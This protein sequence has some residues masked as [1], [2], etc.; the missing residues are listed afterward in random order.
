MKIYRMI[1]YDMR[2]GFWQNRW[3]LLIMAALALFFCADFY[4]YRSN[5]YRG[6]DVPKAT[7]MDYLF[8]FMSGAKEYHVGVDET[9]PFP[10]KWFLLNAYFLYSTLYYSNRDLLG[11]GKVILPRAKS[12]WSWWLS[13]CVWN[14]LYTLCGYG[15]LYA[16]VLLWCVVMGERVSFAITAP[17][18]DKLLGM[19]GM[20]TEYAMM[21]SFYILL[22]PMMTVIS[23]SI[24]QTMFSLITRPVFSFGIM[25][26]IFVLS[27]YFQSSI[28]IGN[29]AMPIRSAY[30]IEGGFRAFG[31]IVWAVVIC[32]LAMLFGGLC[33]QKYDML[34][35]EN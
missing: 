3:K 1:R 6:M 32:L 16:T 31:G 24:L 23:L 2:Q 14:M 5:C 20:H 34:A 22:V 9:V 21:L 33:F 11:M 4:L 13:K 12:R 19:E 28:F 29:Y 26:V 8:Y 25:A 10:A 15:V 35:T 17:L 7:C 27:T 30:V 18:I